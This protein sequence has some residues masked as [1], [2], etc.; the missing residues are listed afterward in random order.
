MFVRN[1]FQL[2]QPRGGV[3][4]TALE[5]AGSMDAACASDCRP[6][7]IQRHIL[8]SRTTIRETV[9]KERCLFFLFMNSWRN[10]ALSDTPKIK[11]LIIDYRAPSL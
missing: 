11:V 10:A 4:A 9:G 5:S 8:A 2:D 6:G 1:V 7:N 3:C